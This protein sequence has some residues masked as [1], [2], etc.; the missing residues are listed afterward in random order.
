[1]LQGG[2]AGTGFF[3]QFCMIITLALTSVQQYLIL[4][5]ILTCTKFVGCIMQI[6][7]Y[8]LLL[9]WI[10]LY[11]FQCAGFL[12]NSEK[13]FYLWML[14]QQALKGLKCI[15]QLELKC[16]WQ[17]RMYNKIFHLVVLTST[18]MKFKNTNSKVYWIT[19]KL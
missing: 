13:M 1:M 3:S 11:S 18:F 5:L 8:F 7:I 16:L 17:S 12:V 15:L 6:V 14:K 9:L 10:L 19:L 2:G 4:W